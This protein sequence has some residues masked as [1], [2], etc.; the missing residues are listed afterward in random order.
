MDLAA[1][2]DEIAARLA[3]IAG[4]KVYPYPPDLLVPPGAIVDYPATVTYGTV[5]GRGF[6]TTLPV[7]V[8]VGRP[9]DRGTAAALAAYAADSGASSV[10]VALESGACAA[11]DVLNVT[12][13][14]F[15]AVDIA[16]VV[17]M[18]ARFECDIVGS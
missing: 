11:F 15:D 9:T 5:Y 2:M 7:W 10:K 13:V 17:Y 8:V 16:A 3:T 12:E 6:R 4:L 1:V 18:G 14:E